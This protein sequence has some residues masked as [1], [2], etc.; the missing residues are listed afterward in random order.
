MQRN[1]LIKKS[2]QAWFV[3]AALG[4][5]IFAFY[6]I[7]YYGPSGLFGKWEK[8]NETMPHGHETGDPMNNVAMV[9]HMILAAIILV[10]GPFQFIDHIRKKWARLHRWNGRIYVLSG[11]LLG[12]NGIFIVLY[13]GTIS[14][15]LGDIS[16]SL[17][18]ILIIL[19]A[20]S[21]WNKA[22]EK[23]FNAH[24]KWSIRLFLVMSG[25][26]FFRIGL[27]FWLLVN[28]GKAVWFDMESFNGP[29]LIGLG[30]GQYIIPL[31]IAEI[32]FLAETRS[33]SWIKIPFALFMFG[34]TAMTLVGIFAATFGL[35]LPRLQ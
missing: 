2:V 34:I 35:W 10:G 16:M 31:V 4:T 25:V 7:F 26:W 27:M 1:K 22:I 6:V 9:I 23:N 13:K 29:F 5:W 21:T 17:N 11:L 32:Y 8:W 19:C 3:T 18:A 15:M 14:G 20:L 28:D 12:I 30:F 33:L 24:R